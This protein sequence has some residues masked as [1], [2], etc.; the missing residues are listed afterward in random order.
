MPSCTDLK[1]L[2][3]RVFRFFLNIVTLL[4]TNQLEA[5]IYTD[6]R[7]LLLEQIY[8]LSQAQ[9]TRMSSTG[10]H[11]KAQHAGSSSMGGSSG[12][13]QGGASNPGVPHATG[14]GSTSHASGANHQQQHRW[15]LRYTC[16][17]D[18]L[19]LFEM[20]RGVCV[21]T[22]AHCRIEINK[23]AL[24]GM[25]FIQFE[26]SFDDPFGFEDT[27]DVALCSAVCICIGDKKSRDARVDCGAC[28]LSFTT[29]D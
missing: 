2:T 23:H 25:S 17:L 13:G 12:E 16:S 18:L 27:F 20:R 8:T 14:D 1:V 3:A 26:E 5:Y 21:F 28:R 4:S 10:D 11:G 6:G 9:I 15:T 7:A 19:F 22:R 24:S 29:D